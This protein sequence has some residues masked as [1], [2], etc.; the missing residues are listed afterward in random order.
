MNSVLNNEHPDLVVLNGDLT[1]C[2]YVAPENITALINQVTTPLVD[3]NVPFA[4]TFG[5]H[6]MSKTCSTRT[7]SEHMWN[8]IKGKNGQKLSFTASSVSGPYE[9]VGTSNY[10]IPVYAS[11]GG[12][13]PQLSMMLWFFD[14]KGGRDYDKVDANG[15]DVPVDSWVDD[16]VSRSTTSRCHCP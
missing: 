3:R 2:E 15:K 7:M 12:G 1:S 11:K 13:N 8:N 6:D 9:Q 5:N 4:A 14:S 10:Y 16:K